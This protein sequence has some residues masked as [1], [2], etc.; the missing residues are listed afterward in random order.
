MT[1][2]QI[3]SHIL[4]QQTRNHPHSAQR[5]AQSANSAHRAASASGDSVKFQLTF[6][7]KLEIEIE[8]S[9]TI[10]I[11][12]EFRRI[13]RNN[14]TQQLVYRIDRDRFQMR[15]NTFLNRKFPDSDLVDQPIE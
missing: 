15:R 1:D 11:S 14:D 4:I 8:A 3:L 13:A 2:Y 6:F 5:T 12:D 9:T 7:L 10:K